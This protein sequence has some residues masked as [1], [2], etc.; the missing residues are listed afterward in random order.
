V[1]SSPFLVNAT[2][3][4]RGC[5]L[6]AAVQGATVGWLILLAAE[7]PTAAS[8]IGLVGCVGALAV[9]WP[10]LW[11]SANIRALAFTGNASRNVMLVWDHGDGANAQELPLVWSWSWGARLAVLGL[12]R[13]RAARW[14]LIDHGAVSVGD[15]AR[16]Y[17][18]M[19]DA[20]ST[21]PEAVNRW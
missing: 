19:R 2:W 11:R 17:R 18:Q 12:G 16:F 21:Q 5:A 7:Q 3:F 14:A 4:R 6:L 1:T 15:T 20:T 10:P 8:W 13:G 9:A